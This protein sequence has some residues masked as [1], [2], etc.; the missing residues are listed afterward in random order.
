MTE[1]D[2]KKKE[3]DERKATEEAA[4]KAAE[5][6]KNNPDN[7]AGPGEEVEKSGKS[8]LD[9]A[10]DIN[11]VKAENLAKEE[12]LIARKEKLAAI[13]LVGG[14]TKAGEESSEKKGQTN[15]EYRKEVEGKLAAGQ[16]DFT[17]GN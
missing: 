13:Q 10:E 9:R 6:A 3:E 11:K 17:D 2:E 16:T 14:R 15:S 5:D 4:T 8:E 7:G 12:K 1:E